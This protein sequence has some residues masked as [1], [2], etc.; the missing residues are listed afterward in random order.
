MSA[1]DHGRTGKAVE[2]LVAASSILMSG[3]ALNASTALVDD[4]GVDLV[5]HRRDGTATLGVQV[6]SRTT[7]AAT[8]QRGRFLADVRSETFRPRDDLYILYVVV[9]R[10]DAVL[11]LLWLVPSRVLAERKAPNSQGRLRFSASMNPESRDQWSQ[12]R[13]ERQELAPRILAL[14]DEIEGRRRPGVQG[15][16]SDAGKAL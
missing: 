6:K 2:Y 14:L 9:D 8:I 15:R 13:V 4:E 3:G 16:S 7:D 12:F 11:A 10:V 1:A 5:F